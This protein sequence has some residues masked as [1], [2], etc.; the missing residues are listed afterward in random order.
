M[1]ISITATTVSRLKPKMCSPAQITC[2]H[3]LRSSG[4]QNLYG[5][6]FHPEKSQDL[7]LLIL[8]NFV[9]RCL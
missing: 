6:Q 8:R 9:E 2:W 7:G 4:A 1:L 3:T 5:V